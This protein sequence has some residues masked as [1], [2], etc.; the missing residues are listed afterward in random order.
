MLADIKLSNDWKQEKLPSSYIAD[1]F[2]LKTSQI[3]LLYS[4]TVIEYNYREGEDEE[5]KNV[6]F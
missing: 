4:I 1:E 3:I 5:K 6:L 2:Y